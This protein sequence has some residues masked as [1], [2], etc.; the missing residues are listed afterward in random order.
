MAHRYETGR[1]KEPYSDDFSLGNH[2]IG[3]LSPSR[4]HTLERKRRVSVRGVAMQIGFIWF[5]F[6]ARRSGEE[7]HFDPQI[8]KGQSA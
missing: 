8:V 1:I 4:A 7:R 2:D 6:L 5:L 3:R